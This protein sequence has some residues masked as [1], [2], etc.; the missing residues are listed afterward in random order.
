MGHTY[1]GVFI[2]CIF[3]TK[4]RRP[5]IAEDRETGLYNYLGGIAKGEGLSLIAA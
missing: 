3:S 4:E 1:S 5:L 2:H